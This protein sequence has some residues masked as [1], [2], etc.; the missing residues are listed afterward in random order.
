MA[1]SADNVNNGEFLILTFKVLDSTE[2][3]TDVSVQY[4][5]GDICNFNTK[6]VNFIV[7]AGGVNISKKPGDV[8][9][10]NSL[11]ARDLSRLMRLIADDK[12]FDDPECINADVNGDGTVNAKDIAR[13]MK[14]IAESE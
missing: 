9:G 12:G 7:T 11:D 13:L 2:G 1:A 8:N 3:F 5:Y 10:D 14:L 6:V 4:S